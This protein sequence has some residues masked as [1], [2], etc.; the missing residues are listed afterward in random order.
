MQR[1]DGQCKDPRL[2]LRSRSRSTSSMNGTML[3]RLLLTADDPA[4]ADSS[5]DWRAIEALL[6]HFAV[7]FE[8]GLSC[9]EADTATFME[10]LSDEPKR[11][12]HLN[13]FECALLFEH[14]H[15]DC[16]D[17]VNATTDTLN[18]AH[19]IDALALRLLRAADDT[20]S[21]H[22]IRI[23]MEMRIMIDE[24]SMRFVR[25]A[26]SSAPDISSLKLKGIDGDGPQLLGDVATAQD[27]TAG[28]DSAVGAKLLGR[29]FVFA[30]ALSYDSDARQQRGHP[31]RIAVRC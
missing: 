12:D 5:A 24:R 16:T 19:R 20:Q 29:T 18:G 2:R 3:E 26:N 17:E 25:S 7:D 27:R 8:S 23:W 6:L 22:A 31:I 13:E 21:G 15:D 1:L 11:D 10:V 30:F 4:L 9:S 28:E 14:E